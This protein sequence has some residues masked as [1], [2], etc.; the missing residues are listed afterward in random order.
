MAVGGRLPDG[1]LVFSRLEVFYSRNKTEL[2]LHAIR[3][4]GT[5]D[6][7]FDADRTVHVISGALDY[8]W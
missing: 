2:T 6:T 5:L 7:S 8:R 3:A 4:D 1:R